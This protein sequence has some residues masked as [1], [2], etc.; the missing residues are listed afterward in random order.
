LDTKTFFNISYGMYIVSSLDGDKL[1]AQIANTVFQITAEPPKIGISLNKQ[2]L[3]CEFIKKSG[4]FSVTILSKE[5]SMN[6]IGNFGFKSG[7]DFNKFD[8][9]IYKTG[10][11]GAPIV[12]ENAIGYLEAKVTGSIDAG[13]HIVFLA[14]IT[15]AQI[16]KAGEPMTYSYYHNVKKGSSPKTAPTYLKEQPLT[17]VKKST[18]DKYKCTVCGYVYDPEKGDPENGVGTQ[19]PFENLPENWVCPVCGAGKEVFEKEV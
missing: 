16:V 4:V 18:M 1:N 9:I 15:D 14:E 3:T 17:E 19:T 8:K 13:T 10:I 12:T 2:N 5:T 7:R 6:F 11:N